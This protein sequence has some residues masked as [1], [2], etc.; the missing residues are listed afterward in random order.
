MRNRLLATAT[1]LALV[2]GGA[3]AAHAEPRSTT[4]PQGECDS[5]QA[6]AGTELAAHY[7]ASG[8]QI[9]R[10]SDS[11][12]TLVGPDAVL[13]ADAGR[14]SKVGTHYAGP[15]WESA[16]GGKVVGA[17]ARRCVPDSGAIPWLSLR[18]VSSAE[19][20]IFRRVTFIQRLHTVGGLAP[21][22][23]GRSAGDEARV[24]Y[25]AEYFFYR[26]K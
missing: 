11:T 1:A 26:P 22:A 8:V 7:Y 12:W 25:T 9:Y 2:F 10:W 15:T 21:S 6:P 20:G 17:T 23:P 14:A 3:R 4:V 16:D 19:S 13:F 24:P 18:A 5:L